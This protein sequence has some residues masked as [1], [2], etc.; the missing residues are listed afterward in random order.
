MDKA[1]EIAN[2]FGKGA[3]RGQ[4]YLMGKRGRKGQKGGI[5][6][7]LPLLGSIL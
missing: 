6:P 3:F 7:L 1:F 2:Q 5:I 4:M